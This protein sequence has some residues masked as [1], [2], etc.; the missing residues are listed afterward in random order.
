MIVG[1]STRTPKI[2]AS[3]PSPTAPAPPD[4][5][6]LTIESAPSAV[7]PRP[8]AVRP[9]ELPL[10][11]TTVSRMAA[12]GGTVVALRA[13]MIEAIT[14][15]A[16]PIRNGP[17]NELAPT[18]SDP[19]M[20][21]PSVAK[22]DWSTTA[23][24]MPPMI[25]TSEASTPTRRLSPSTPAMICGRLAPMAR[26]RARSRVRWAITIAKVLWMMNAPTKSA[27]AANASR[28]ELSIPSE[29]RTLSRFSR[30]TSSPVSTC[31]SG[32]AAATEERRS[33]SLTPGSADAATAWI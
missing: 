29:S 14:Q 7:R 28:K 25:P 10:S 17:T 13:G 31:I 3:A 4:A 9:R 2:T 33:V 6:P 8:V 11:S 12:T 24:P 27:T 20:S 19:A 23:T 22:S 16:T 26:S 5:R 32:R 1:P 21:S 15:T 18:A 30:V